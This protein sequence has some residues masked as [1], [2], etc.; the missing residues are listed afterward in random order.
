[1][2]EQQQSIN[3]AGIIGE[4]LQVP[5]VCLLSGR[6]NKKIIKLRSLVLFL[7]SSKCIPLNDCWEATVPHVQQKIGNLLKRRWVEVQS[8]SLTSHQ[9]TCLETL[10]SGMVLK[11]RSFFFQHNNILNSVRTSFH[12]LANLTIT[13]YF[14]K[15]LLHAH[16]NQTF[17]PFPP[18]EKCAVCGTACKYLALSD[19]VSFSFSVTILSCFLMYRK[20]TKNTVTMN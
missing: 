11:L 16:E 2:Q 19:N 12:Q 13:T 5:N 7:D 10:I 3:R 9:H 20:Y 1:M 14:G 4:F 17:F 8:E 18:L 15:I 6:W